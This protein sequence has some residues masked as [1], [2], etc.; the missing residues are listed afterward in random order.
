MIVKSLLL[1]FGHAIESF[2]HFVS[3]QKKRRKSSS[4][5]PKVRKRVRQQIKERSKEN[6]VTN[7]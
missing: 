3:D 6:Q 4:I 5:A 1:S 2:R 7:R